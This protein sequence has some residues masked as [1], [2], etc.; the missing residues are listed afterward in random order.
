MGYNESLKTYWIYIH[1]QRQIEISI[2]VFFEE[3][4]APQISRESHMET[5]SETIPYPTSAVH[6]EARIIL[7]DPV[8]PVLLVAPVDIPKDIAVGH[9][10]ACLGSTKLCRRQRNIQFPQGAS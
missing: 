4:I 9:K 8:L 1:G 10:K 3:E 7:V 2:N 5:D 6:R